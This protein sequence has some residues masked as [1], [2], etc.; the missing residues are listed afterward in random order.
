MKISTRR[1]VVIGMLAAISIVLGATPLG[2]IALPFSPTKATIMHIPVIIG[3]IMEGP[4]VGLFIGLVFG[5]F[6]MYQAVAMPTS[7]AQFVFLDPIVAIL[8]RLCIAIT[9]YY[10][11]VGIKRLFKDRDSSKGAKGSHM[12]ASAF[13][14]AVGTVTNTAGVLS[15]I[16]LRHGVEYAGK[17]GIPAAGLGKFLIGIAVTHGIPEIVVA[18]VIVS[19]VTGALQKIYNKGF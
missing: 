18:I 7:P 12:L 19:A 6:S 5:G 17:I 2:F 16:Y 1:L 9:S 15:A 14:G 10:T 13:A 3:S 8:P 4:V 11:Y